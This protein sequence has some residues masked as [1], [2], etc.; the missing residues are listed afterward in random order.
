MNH[1]VNEIREVRKEY[2][3]SDAAECPPESNGIVE[4]YRKQQR[5]EVHAY[6]QNSCCNAPLRNSEGHR[7]S[8]QNQ[9]RSKGPEYEPTAAE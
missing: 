6:N 8:K 9:E 7:N 1:L 2:N 3:C 4:T 5:A